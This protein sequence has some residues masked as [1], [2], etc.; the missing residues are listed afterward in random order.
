M[1]G[2]SQESIKMTGSDLHISLN[3]NINKDPQPDNG[4]QMVIN[5][6]ALV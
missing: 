6:K 2:E 5:A 4:S 1:T 3:R